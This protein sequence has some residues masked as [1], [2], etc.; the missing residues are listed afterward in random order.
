MVLCGVGRSTHGF[1]VFLLLWGW[2]SDGGVLRIGFCGV[3]RI[4]QSVEGERTR[5]D[6]NKSSGNKNNK[7]EDKV[8][9]PR[10]CS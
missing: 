3:W 7:K 9:V 10:L 1:F 5:K 4:C 6:V 8:S 2:E